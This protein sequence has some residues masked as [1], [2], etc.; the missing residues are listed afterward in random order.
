MELQILI[1][2]LKELKSKGF[3]QSK[4][5]GP[6]GI[7][8]TLECELGIIE[9]NIALPDLEF[10]E[11][12]AHRDNHT[13]LITLFTFNK[14]AWQ[15]PQLEAIEK[16]GSYDKKNR[17]GLYYSIT[18]QQNSAG[19]FLNCKEE[20]ILIQH[21]SG[22]VI[23]KWT[24]DS[25]VEKFSE[26]IPALVLVTAQTEERDGREFFYYYKSQLMHTT[27]RN[28]L[29]NAFKTGGIIID[30]RLHDKGTRARNHGTGFRV[31]QN[32]FANLF[33]TITDLGV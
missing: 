7:G 8:Y 14:K 23:V 25:V 31:S 15:L 6:T 10:A 32:N 11:L 19:L 5:K 9:N 21:T 17:K 3:I 27:T 24:I 30:L 33:A 16:Y 2:K 13:G 18:P 29:L 22:E 26:K 1:Q 12:K 4:R 28:T 20:H